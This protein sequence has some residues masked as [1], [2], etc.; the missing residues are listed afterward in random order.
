MS[1][2][3]NFMNWENLGTALIT[4]A[5]AGIG[6]EF[7]RQLAEQG[8]NLILIARRK[9]KLEA[10][11]NEI[12][13]KNSINVEI[14]V[15]DLTNI[16]VNEKFIEKIAELDDLDV[17]INNAGYGLNIP[18]LEWKNQDILNMVNL[19]LM[20]PIMFFLPL[21][22]VHK[23]MYNSKKK[24]QNQVADKFDEEFYKTKDL[25]NKTTQDLTESIDRVE[26]LQ[27]LSDMAKIFP[28]W[29]YNTKNIIRFFSSVL[30]PIVL[31]FLS[32]LIEMVVLGQLNIFL[33]KGFQCVNKIN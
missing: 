17:L 21:S 28:V 19:H 23:S 18:F 3:Q 22:V 20:S 33:T 14:W 15:G 8:F 7:A 29:P 25:L 13:Q 6:G 16:E 10:I 24:F 5:S 1:E 31:C 32:V 11:K 2:K 27:R 30:F 26:Q 4:G 9:E 12:Q